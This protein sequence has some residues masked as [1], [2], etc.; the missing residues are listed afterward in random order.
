MHLQS[1]QDDGLRQWLDVRDVRVFIAVLARRVVGALEL[2]LFA[3]RLLLALLFGLFLLAPSLKYSEPTCS[4]HVG[5]LAQGM[6]IAFEN[7][8]VSGDLTDTGILLAMKQ[9]LRG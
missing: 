8:P 6:P 9:V 7:L 3:P 2:A 4:C 5:S 1:A